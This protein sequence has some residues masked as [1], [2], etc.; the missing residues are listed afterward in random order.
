MRN[1][2][3]LR[4][5]LLTTSLRDI[6][7]SITVII[8]APDGHLQTKTSFHYV[9]HNPRWTLGARHAPLWTGSRSVAAATTAARAGREPMAK[10]T[11]KGDWVR[12][13]RKSNLSVLLQPLN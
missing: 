9:V 3:T 8:S 11:A 2:R 12:L 13:Q 1:L 5:L 6:K 7:P 4:A 10:G